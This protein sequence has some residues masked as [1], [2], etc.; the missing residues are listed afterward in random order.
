MR[1]PEGAVVGKL[2]NGGGATAHAL[3]Q[4]QAIPLADGLSVISGWGDRSDVELVCK[5][6]PGAHVSVNGR[7]R[8]GMFVIGPGQAFSLRTGGAAE[9]TWTL[10]SAEQVPVAAEPTGRCVFCHRTLG[11]AGVIIDATGLPP[12]WRAL[13]DG[14]LCRKCAA[15]IAEARRPTH[16]RAR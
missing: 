9:Q 16:G 6:S 3:V 15:G 1:A 14:P 2:V 12:R 8:A 7:R 13:V 10:I 4:G 11:G 5:V